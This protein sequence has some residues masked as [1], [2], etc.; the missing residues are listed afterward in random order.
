VLFIKDAAQETS[1]SL[2]EKLKYLE[3]LYAD[4]GFK[5]YVVFQNPDQRAPVEELAQKLGTTFPVT[6][7]EGGV[8]GPGGKAY[9]LNPEAENTVLVMKGN[10]VVA[11]RVN[12]KPQTFLQV[13]LEA[14][15]MLTGS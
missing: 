5:A 2:V 11:N 7:L 15:K 14:A 10:K 1:A 6:L 4:N 13:A 8:E 12:V 3:K 9:Q